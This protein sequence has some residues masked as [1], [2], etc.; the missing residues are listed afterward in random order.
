MQRL[1]IKRLVDTIIRSRF[2]SVLADENILCIMPVTVDFVFD[3]SLMI[4]QSKNTLRRLALHKMDFI[5]FRRKCNLLCKSLRARPHHRIA[6]F[7]SEKDAKLIKNKC[8]L[9]DSLLQIKNSRVNSI[10]NVK[11]ALFILLVCV[12]CVI[13]LCCEN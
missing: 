9:L 13:R 2:L 10:D 6:N 7:F 11:I 1:D 12:N 4:S 3:A 8:Q 5:P